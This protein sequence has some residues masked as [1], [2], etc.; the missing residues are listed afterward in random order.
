MDTSTN[1]KGVRVNKCGRVSLNKS[2]FCVLLFDFIHDK[3]SDLSA[4]F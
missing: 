2:H 3:R 1:A 4:A